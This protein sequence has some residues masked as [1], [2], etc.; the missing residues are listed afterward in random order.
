[1]IYIAQ[2]EGYR[3]ITLKVLVFL[4]AANK[5]IPNA[6]VMKTDDDTY[7]RMSE[8]IKLVKQHHDQHFYTGGHCGSKTIVRRPDDPWYVSHDVLPGDKYPP[9]AY[10]GGYLLSSTTNQCAVN[11]MWKRNDT[12]LSPVEDA[13]V[14]VL[15]EPCRVECTRD[16]RFMTGSP[17]RGINQRQPEYINERL[18]IHKVPTYEMMLAMHDQACCN[19]TLPI[20]RMH[21]VTADPIS[22][23]TTIPHCPL[24]FLKNES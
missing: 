1:L 16:A 4:A 9:F 7:V 6:A 21:N 2:P 18:V 23:G 10:G 5:H 19:T 3:L 14:G 11:T 20:R 24:A 12:I 13:Y 17:V 22:C 15:V 8:M